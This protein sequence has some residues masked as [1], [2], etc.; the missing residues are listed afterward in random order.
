MLG[1]PP[2]TIPERS[3]S[4][5]INAIENYLFRCEAGP[6]KEL[7]RVDRTEEAVGGLMFRFWHSLR[8]LMRILRRASGSRPRSR[9]R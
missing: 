7:C 1:D 9:W 3:N 5:L 2:T 8:R 4:D 6:L